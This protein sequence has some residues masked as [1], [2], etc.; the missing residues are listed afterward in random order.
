[1]TKL[2]GRPSAILLLS[3]ADTAVALVS[4]FAASFIRAN[5]LTR[6]PSLWSGE[7][8]LL[9]TYTVLL[10]GSLPIIVCALYMAGAYSWPRLSSRVQTLA[11]VSK[12][13]AL[14]SLMVFSAAYALRDMAFSR[15]IVVSYLIITFATAFLVRLVFCRWFLRRLRQGH[16]LQNAVIVGTG[17][18]ASAIADS[19]RRKP[20]LGYRVT[21]FVRVDGE[22]YDD[23]S[24]ETL[25][26]VE[27]LPRIV[28]EEV[29]DTVVFG[30]S[31]EEAARCE[32]I[33]WK[34]EEVGKTVHLR[35]DAIGVMLSRTFIGEF[36][37]LPMLTLESTPGDPIALAIKRAIDLVGSGLG[38]LF[39][40][41]LLLAAAIAVKV[42]S[43]GPA[44]YRQRRVGLNGRLFTIYKFR[45]MYVD[46]EARQAE[47]RR[48]NEMSGPVF[49]M[50]NDPRITPVGRWI[51]KYSVDELP[52]LW[53]VFVGAASRACGRRAA[54]T[55][56]TSRPG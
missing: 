1:M 48:H 20:Y 50:T 6:W 55:R 2:P 56:S 26:T 19:M 17:P 22:R 24:V 3:L 38:L 28:D 23:P 42:S 34:L 33:I 4:L 13:F 15:A 44:F 54:A 9:P 45:S 53:N 36:D 43:P 52:Q 25:G 32:R 49:K 51:R 8:P 14:A 31:L 12:A 35:G 16:G 41:P 29:V 30:I 47:L 40:S 21:G 7:V 11:S 18:A 10:L 5:V 27:E 37:G 39:L 46:A